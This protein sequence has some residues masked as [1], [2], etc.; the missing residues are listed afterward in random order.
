MFLL[1]S[2]KVVDVY[3]KY[4]SDKNQICTSVDFHVDYCIEI[5]GGASIPATVDSLRKV[6]RLSNE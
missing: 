6:Y 1:D 4:N 3:V 2:G 5:A